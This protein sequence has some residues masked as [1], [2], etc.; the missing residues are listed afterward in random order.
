M[1]FS[2]ASGNGHFNTNVVFDNVRMHDVVEGCVSAL[3][4][5]AKDSA[6]R[7]IVRNVNVVSIL[8]QV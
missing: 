6:N 1:F 2:Q 3:Y 5:L 4:D 7:D 8:V